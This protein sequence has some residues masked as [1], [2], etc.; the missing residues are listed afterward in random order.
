M[1]IV[2]FRRP[3]RRGLLFPLIAGLLLGGAGFAV[4]SRDG[5]PGFAGVQAS[6]QDAE[7]G[8]RVRVI[9]GDTIEDTS[10]GERIRLPNIDTP[11]TGERAQCFAERQAGEAATRAAREIAAGGTVTVRRTGRIDRYGRTIGFVQVDGHDLGEIMMERGLA[12]PW[13][14]R[15]EAWCAA[16]GSLL[17]AQ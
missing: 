15:R 7:Q 11:E 10:T 9:D 8:I 1:T 16:D 13:R 5:A 12:R 4:I 2:K 6:V 17:T 3:F 14:G